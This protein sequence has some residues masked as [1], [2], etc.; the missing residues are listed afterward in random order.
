MQD[1][2]PDLAEIGAIVED[3][4]KDDQRAGAVIDRMRAL[5]G[6]RRSRWSR[7]TSARCSAMSQRCCGPMPR[8]ACE[9][10]G[11]DVPEGLPAVRGD[12]VQLQQV[13]LNLVLNGMDALEGVAGE[14]RVS[15][16][17]RRET[18]DTVEI[19]VRDSG[20]GVPADQLERIFDP[21]FSTK[22]RASAWDCRS[23]QH[24][25]DPPR[26]PLGREQRGRGS[27]LPLHAAHGARTPP[28]DARDTIHSEVT[29]MTEP[30]V[31]VVDDDGSFLLSMSRWLRASGFAVKTYTSASEFL[32]RQD[33]DD[34]PDA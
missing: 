17:A 24:H 2:S 13:L 1:P 20:R 30:T 14:G 33:A 21:F 34:S 32:A 26:P 23:P 28:I 12:R 6:A 27:D 18:A 7:S 19:S 15:V 31:H 11:S 4:R 16:T 3:I 9:D 5:L 29:N 22:R 25:R 8:R 10:S